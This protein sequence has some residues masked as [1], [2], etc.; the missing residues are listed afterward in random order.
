MK[1]TQTKFAVTLVGGLALCLGAATAG[2]NGFY[3]SV[4]TG[5]ESQKWPTTRGE[6][7]SGKESSADVWGFPSQHYMFLPY[8]YVIGGTVH[9]NADYDVHGPFVG[10][11][12]E[13]TRIAKEL[14]NPVTIYYN[15]A[16]PEQSVL[17]PGISFDHITLAYLTVA[18]IG[19]IVAFF[20]L[21]QLLGNRR[22]STQ[23]SRPNETAP[24][25]ASPHSR[26]PPPS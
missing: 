7:T 4:V 22:A 15:P 16:N 2:Y 18:L 14:Q 21:Y 13:T 6:I 1:T 26:E 9:T 10:T 20:S 25:A 24:S 3:L 5:I 19:L 17:R 8:Q 11:P 12:K 23:P